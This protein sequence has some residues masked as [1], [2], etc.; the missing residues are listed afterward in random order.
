MCTGSYLQLL[1]T[2]Q[3]IARFSAKRAKLSTDETT[4]ATVTKIIEEIYRDG[5]LALERFSKEF[6]NFAIVPGKIK[7]PLSVI[8]SAGQR[9]TPE[10][11]KAIEVAALRIENYHQRQKQ[12]S[13]FYT[14]D[15][16]LFGQLVTPLDAAGLYVPGGK[17]AYPSTVL[18]NA[19][20][21][22]MAGVERIVIC[23]PP[24]KTGNIP[25]TILYAAHL[26]GV[27]EIYPI[28]GAQA[29]AA[30]AYGTESIKPVDKICG[31]G[32][33]FVAE[34]KRQV[35]GA[36]DIDMIAGPSEIM[37]Y[38]DKFS[39]PDI[40]AADLFSQAEHDEDARVIV[41]CDDCN[42]IKN[43]EASISQQ[44][45][46]T[47]RKKIIQNSLQNNGLAVLVADP[48]E[49]YQVINSCAPEHL[50]ILA[51]RPF[52]EICSQVKHAGAVFIGNWSPEP[53]GDYL[54]GPNH[55]LPTSGTARFA[56]PLG[57]YD[58]VKRSSVIRFDAENFHKLAPFAAVF[59]DAEG[60][61]A[62]ADSIRMRLDNK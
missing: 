52:E 38:A 50:E 37:I 44:L 28:G 42:T 47:T 62:H 55:T 17:A 4:A 24:D 8:A 16:S 60:L 34:A 39:N 46:N 32:N 7:L 10:L 25:D 48:R 13:W 6:D 2:N 5:D 54:A 49:A 1:D 43:V 31:P 53:M 30:L 56:S 61:N 12:S 51:Q 15:Q 19:I 18:M 11:K 21:A 29:V 41:V 40:I 9:L 14:E 27:D 20:P 33:R 59:A 26:T 23:T 58:F 3:A 35:F 22:K 36:V 57:V 45:K